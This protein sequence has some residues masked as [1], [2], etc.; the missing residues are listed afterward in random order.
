LWRE[1]SQ[2]WS[3]TFTYDQWS[4][5]NKS[6]SVNFSSQGGIGNHAPGLTY[7][8]NGRVISAQ[9]G[10]LLQLP[11]DESFAWAE[12]SGHKPKSGALWKRCRHPQKSTNS[13]IKST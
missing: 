2:A 12:L 6:G 3:Q 5:I 4:N 10:Y 8:A 11:S 9:S 13:T 7:D 1:L